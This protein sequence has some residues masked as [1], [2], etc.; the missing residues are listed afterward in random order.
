MP[1]I[2]VSEVG[3]DRLGMVAQDV[4]NAVRDE[5]LLVALVVVYRLGGRCFP[6]VSCASL[7]AAM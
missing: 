4:E 6:T 1:G 7:R 5:L 2:V 3:L